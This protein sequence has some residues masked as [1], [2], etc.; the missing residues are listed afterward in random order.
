MYSVSLIDTGVF[1]FSGSSCKGF[2]KLYFLRICSFHP[3]CQILWYYVYNILL[4]Y[5]CRSYSDS[6]YLF[7][8]LLICVF[9]LFLF[10]TNPGRFINFVNLLIKKPIFIK[11]FFLYDMLFF[12]FLWFFSVILSSHFHLQFW[13]WPAIL[14]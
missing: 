13:F 9:S 2:N 3:N 7:F 12:L 1:R 6:T 14:F 10:R 4:F 5:F 11:K 8:L